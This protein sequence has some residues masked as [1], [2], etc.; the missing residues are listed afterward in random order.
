MPR[1]QERRVI[2]EGIRKRNFCFVIQEFS[3]DRLVPDTSFTLA[4]EK[5]MYLQ[6]NNKYK[7]S[8]QIQRIPKKSAE[9]AEKHE[10]I[11]RFDRVSNDRAFDHPSRWS[12]GKRFERWRN[13]RSRLVPAGVGIVI[14]MH[15]VSRTIKRNSH[16]ASVQ[17]G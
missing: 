2:D 14:A 9:T 7:N 6:G 13:G 16:S 17:E 5:K 1:R 15:M 11:G 3:K 8:L 12:R 4:E 10:G